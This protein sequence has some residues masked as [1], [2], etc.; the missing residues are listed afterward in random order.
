LGQRRFED[1][2]KGD[3]WSGVVAIVATAGQRQKSAL[4]RLRPGLVGQA[5]FADARRAGNHHH[6]S[7]AIRRLLQAAA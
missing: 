6:A 7:F 3:E 4:R 5:S 2:N 1:L